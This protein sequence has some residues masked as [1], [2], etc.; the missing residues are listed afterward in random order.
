MLPLNFLD[1]GHSRSREVPFS[2]SALLQGRERGPDSVRHHQSKLIR[3]AQ[4]LDQGAED[5]R[6]EEHG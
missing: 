6:A 3:G 1:L 5:P 2:G 4:E